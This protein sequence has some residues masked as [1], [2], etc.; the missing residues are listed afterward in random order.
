MYNFTDLNIAILIA[1]A[2]GLPNVTTR[3]ENKKATYEPYICNTC[4]AFIYAYEFCEDLRN[5]WLIKKYRLL[6][7]SSKCQQLYLI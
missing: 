5:A 4:V 6:I 2:P 7:F 1:I 3:H